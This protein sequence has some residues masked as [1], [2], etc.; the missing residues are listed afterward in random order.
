MNNPSPENHY[1][2]RRAEIKITT[3][4]G[5]PHWDQK[6]KY[7]FITFR[8]ND[9]LPPHIVEQLLAEKTAWLRQHPQPLSDADRIEYYRKFG[10]K[11]DTLCDNAYG[12][13][14]LRNHAAA[15]IVEQELLRVDGVEYSIHA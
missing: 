14:L 4:T 3:T 6:H 11:I 2:D 10:N 12:S 7:Q 1:L 9:S 15:H 5:L 13:C 8:L